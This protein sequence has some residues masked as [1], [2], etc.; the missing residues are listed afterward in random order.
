MCKTQQHKK[1]NHEQNH[2]K[3]NV[4]KQP[5]QQLS[6]NMP[7]KHYTPKHTKTKQPMT[8]NARKPKKKDQTPKEAIYARNKTSEPAIFKKRGKET[9]KKK[10]KTLSQRNAR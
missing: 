7:P 1:Q 3:T 2:G 4:K 6:E 8:K 9:S 5:V 10:M